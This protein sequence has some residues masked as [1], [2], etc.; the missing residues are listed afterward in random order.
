V[1]GVN[2]A[3]FSPT[4][5]SVG[6]GFAVPASL[7]RPVVEQLI[8]GGAVRRGWLGV[9]VQEVTP[10]IAEGLG[11][12]AARGALVVFVD[13]GGPAARAGVRQGDVILSVDGVQVD[14]TRRLPRLVGQKPPG[15]GVRLDMRRAGED[16]RADVRLGELDARVFEEASVGVPPGRDGGGGGGTPPAADPRASEIAGI[17]LAPLQ[18]ALRDAF[19]IDEGVRGALVLGLV[20]GTAASYVGLMPGDVVTAVGTVEVS[21]PDEVRREIDAARRGGQ[22]VALLRVDRAGASLYVPLPLG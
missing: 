7:A 3:I 21:S 16:R 2:T 19:G 11:M 8:E 20:D 13:P 9:Q 17:R 1:V 22:G 5:G 6:I 18:Q 10:E 12:D 15:A 14:R 4:G